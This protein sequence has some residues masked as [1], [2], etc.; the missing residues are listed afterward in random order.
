MFSACQETLEQRCQRE[1]QAYT[2]KNC[3][4][5]IAKDVTIDSLTFD[6]QSHTLCYAYTLGGVLDD[7]AIVNKSELKQQ[8]LMDLR[9]AT[10]LKIY[11]EAG[12]NFRY[13]YY[14]RKQQG[15][16]LLDVIYKAKDYQK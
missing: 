16:K 2:E 7:S 6:K 12:Y 14:S 1:A 15:Q 3:P 9:N 5:L 13:V 8:M 4:A 11:K 10:S